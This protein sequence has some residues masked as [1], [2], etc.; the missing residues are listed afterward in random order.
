MSQDQLQKELKR[1]IAI[2]ISIQS[3]PVIYRAAVSKELMELDEEHM[4]SMVDILLDEQ[5]KQRDKTATLVDEIEAAAKDLKKAFLK[6]REKDE[7][8]ESTEKASD[9]L[10]ELEKSEGKSL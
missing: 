7:V 1:L 8:E 6:E 3:L 4:A 5:E 10:E 2:S 9:L